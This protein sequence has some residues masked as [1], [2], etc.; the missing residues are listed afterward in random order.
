MMRN[1]RVILKFFVFLFILAAKSSESYCK[2]QSEKLPFPKT[3]EKIEK[4][5]KE[6]KSSSIS[7]AVAKDGKIIWEESFGFADVEKNIKATPHTM[8][9]LGS[10]GKVYTATAIMILTERGLIDLD[11]SIDEMQTAPESISSK[12]PYRIGWS[13]YIKYNYRIFRH[14]GHVLGALSSLRIIPSENIAVAVVSNG[15]KANTPLVCE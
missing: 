3:R 2:Q 13:T 14:G 5:L 4:H 11:K 6:T 7:V 8:Y 10:L 15:E 1:L 9:H 12:S